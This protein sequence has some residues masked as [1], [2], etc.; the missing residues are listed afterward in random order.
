MNEKDKEELVEYIF[1]T[2]ALI[3]YLITLFMGYGGF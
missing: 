3:G 2:V 1:F